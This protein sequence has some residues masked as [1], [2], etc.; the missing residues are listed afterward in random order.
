MRIARL[1][2][3]RATFP[4]V[5]LPAKGSST[6][7]LA[8]EVAKMQG[9]TIF[10]GKVA[11]CAPLYGTVATDQT[12]RRLRPEGLPTARVRPIFELLLAFE[13]GSESS[14]CFPPIRSSPSVIFRT[15]DGPDW[16][17]S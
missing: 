12:L 9:D 10:G 11:K 5:P 17:A 2:N 8:G 1:P 15:S 7:P 13:N 4:V 6:V 14:L 3:S 16:Q